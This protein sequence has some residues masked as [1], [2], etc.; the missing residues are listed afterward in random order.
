MA[1]RKTD[2]AFHQA[3]EAARQLVRVWYIYGII[4]CVNHAGHYNVMKKQYEF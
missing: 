3:R 2:A 4:M 1:R